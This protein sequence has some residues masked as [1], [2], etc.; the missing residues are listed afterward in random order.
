MTYRKVIL[1]LITALAIISGSRG[2][3]LTNQ[4]SSSPAPASASIGL[5][6]PASAPGMK[7]TDELIEF[8]QG[9]FERNPR[10][11]ISLTFLGEAFIRKAR[12][13]GDVSEYERADTTLQKALE[14]HPD[15]EVAEAYLSTVLY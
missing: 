15:Y 3:S 13:T 7:T 1:M 2:L 8:W 9:R 6:H 11:F 10:D 14:M 5:E 12:E 4:A